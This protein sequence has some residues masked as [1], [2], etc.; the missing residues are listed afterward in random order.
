M[1]GALSWDSWRFAEVE[2]TDGD[3][4]EHAPDVRLLFTP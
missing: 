4:E 3:N 1:T 2:Q